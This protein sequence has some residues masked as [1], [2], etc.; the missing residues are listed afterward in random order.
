MPKVSNRSRGALAKDAV[1]D[2]A[3]SKSCIQVPRKVVISSALF[4]RLIR[5]V[6]SVPR[7]L[8]VRVRSL[9][10]KPRPIRSEEHTSELKSLMHLSY[11]VFCLKKYTTSIIHT[12]PYGHT[13]ITRH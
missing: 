6:T 7:K 2:R 1:I 13:R 12:H 4:D 10:S 8:R 11:A 3:V 9:S 5:P